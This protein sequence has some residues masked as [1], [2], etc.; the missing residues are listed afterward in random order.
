[1]PD[2]F[3]ILRHDLELPVPEPAHPGDAGFDVY[4]ASDAVLE[5]GARAQIPTGISVACPEGYAVLVL[6][7][8]GLA[9]KHGISLVNT[10]GLIDSGYRGEV[11]VLVINHDP[12]HP[13]EVRRGDRIAQLVPIKLA[14][15]PVWESQAL[16][17][18]ARGESGFGSTGR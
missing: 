18:S 5:P 3:L 16:P 11:Q 14:D 10:P 15:L 2:A 9:A 17:E 12:I 6:P 13:Y 8:S 7:R 1:M 4:A